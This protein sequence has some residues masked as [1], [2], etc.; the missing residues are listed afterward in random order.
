MKTVN[1]LDLVILMILLGAGV[2]YIA[3][4]IQDYYEESYVA[5]SD[6]SLLNSDMGVVNSKVEMTG[7]DVFMQLVIADEF[8]MYPRAVRINDYLIEVT[9]EWLMY[10]TRNLNDLYTWMTTYNEGNLLDWKVT[11]V[12]YVPKDSSAGYIQYLLEE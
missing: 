1:F 3:D 2:Y 7:R 10:K 4:A 12:R 6:K 5:R 8:T 9:D 11:S